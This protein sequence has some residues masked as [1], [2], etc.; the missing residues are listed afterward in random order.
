MSIEVHVTK[1]YA[2]DITSRVDGYFI[3]NGEKVRF[4]GIAFGRIG[5]HNV[6]VNVS[7]KTKGMLKRMGY[8]P[9]DILVKVQRKMVEGDIIIDG[10]E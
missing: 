2:S 7:N 4:K 3:I 8:D 10:N 5:G 6:Y 9:D 1:V